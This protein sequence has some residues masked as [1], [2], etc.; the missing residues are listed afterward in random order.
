M[1]IKLKIQ[2]Q[3]GKQGWGGEKGREGQKVVVNIRATMII[4]MGA[5]PERRLI[6]RSMFGFGFV[7]ACCC[8]CCPFVVVVVVVVVDG[9]F[10]ALRVSILC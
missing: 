3:Y 8:C 10:H 2:Q 6:N 9:T 1:E 5:P 7:F 4:I